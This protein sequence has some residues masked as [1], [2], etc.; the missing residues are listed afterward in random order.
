M[1]LQ[2]SF[3]SVASAVGVLETMTLCSSAHFL[4][5]ANKNISQRFGLI[6]DNLQVEISGGNLFGCVWVQVKKHV[7]TSTFM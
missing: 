3:L 5:G 2:M 1:L 4:A 6:P 7:S